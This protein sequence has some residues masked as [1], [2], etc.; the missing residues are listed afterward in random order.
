MDKIG[1]GGGCHWCTEGVFQSLIGVNH[2]DQGWISSEVPNDNYSEGVIVNFDPQV[3]S[4]HVL[5]EIH[6]LTHSSTSNHSMRDK[7]RSAVYTYDQSQ[8]ENI[9]RIIA[10][11]QIQFDKKIIT[12]V[13]PSINFKRNKQSF[14]NYYQKQPK[15]A[16]CKNHIEPKIQ[17]LVLS[18]SKFVQPVK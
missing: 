7:Y 6:L 11:I 9:H 15:A 12:K 17:Q 8:A 1:F 13:L 2:V 14:L 3:I 10:E 16:F 4:L 18:H 5:V